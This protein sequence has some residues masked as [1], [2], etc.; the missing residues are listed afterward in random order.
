MKVVSGT[1]NITSDEDG[2]IGKDLL[3]IKDGKFTI[4]SGSDGMKS[5]YDKDT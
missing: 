3:G 4:K 1:F 2:I 5:T